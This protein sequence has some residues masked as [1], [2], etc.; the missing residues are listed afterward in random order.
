MTTFAWPEALYP[1]MCELQLAP[2]IRSFES[3]FSRAYQAVDLLG[4]RWTMS[5]TIPARKT[6]RAGAMEAFLHRLRGIHLVAAWHFAR[7][8]PAGTLRG[9]P[10]LPAGAAQGA[11]QLVIAAPVGTT[12][13]AGDMVGAAGQLFMAAADATAD[14]GGA[15]TVPICNRARVALPAGTAVAWNRPTTTWRLASPAS[16]RHVPGAASAVDVDL[17]ETW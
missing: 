5:V 2:N 7:P 10:T 15:L 12:L 9:T 17:I 14:S 13:K 8:V 1:S 16:V 4:E 3:P 11:K 6:A